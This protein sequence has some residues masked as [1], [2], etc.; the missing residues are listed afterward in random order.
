LGGYWLIR[1][2]FKESYTDGIII[3][4]IIITVI[5][6]TIFVI[7]VIIIKG[8]SSSKIYKERGAYF[9]RDGRGRKRRRRACT[10]SK[11]MKN[12]FDRNEGFGLA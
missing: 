6:T 9:R 1:L 8:Y 10:K 7:I 3:I 5:I 12:D 2:I 11:K 4:I